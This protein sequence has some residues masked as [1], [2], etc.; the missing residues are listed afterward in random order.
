MNPKSTRKSSY[1]PTLFPPAY[2]E[3][4]VR[5]RLLSAVLF[6]LDREADAIL[7]GTPC[8][9]SVLGPDG[10]GWRDVD[11]PQLVKALDATGTR[12]IH[13]LGREHRIVSAE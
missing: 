7:A 10:S 3:E 6:A 12:L 1:R 9:V 8:D 5:D 4:Q 11:L 13:K 2:T